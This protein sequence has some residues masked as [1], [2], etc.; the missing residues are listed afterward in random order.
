M[1]QYDI[2]FVFFFQAE[3]GIRDATVTGV[4][5]C[6]LPILSQIGSWQL[7]V[8]FRKARKKQIIQLRSRTYALRTYA[9]DKY[10]PSAVSTRIFSPSLMNGGTCTT[11]PV[12]VFAGLV[13]LE[14]VA[15]FSPGSVS[16]T[17]NST[18]CGNS[19]PT[20]LPSKNST[21]IC[22]LEMR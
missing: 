21:L 18:V 10:A 3:D 22:R 12:S 11:S 20:A 17:V 2:V 8:L 6:A 5:T 15:L 19:M 14:A 16:T 1:K 9:R 13:T 7:Q 4:Q